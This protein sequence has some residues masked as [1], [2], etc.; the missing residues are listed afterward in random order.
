MSFESSGVWQGCSLLNY[1]IDWILGQALQDY[2]GVQIGAS[3]HVSDIAYA[4]DIL[5]LSSSRRG[6]FSIHR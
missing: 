5:I 3:F 6:D 4:D 1:L 2:P